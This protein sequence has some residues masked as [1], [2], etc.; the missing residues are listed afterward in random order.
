MKVTFC[1]QSLIG[2]EI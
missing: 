1:G 2:F